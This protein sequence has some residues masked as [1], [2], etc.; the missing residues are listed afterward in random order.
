MEIQQKDNV[1]EGEI[2]TEGFPVVIAGITAVEK[3]IGGLVGDSKDSMPDDAADAKHDD[4]KDSSDNS[5]EE[6]LTKTFIEGV[7]AGLN[8]ESGDGFIDSSD[9]GSTLGNRDSSFDLN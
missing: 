7:P 1:R 4:F 3:V 2:S 5:Y 6:G 8:E 9:N